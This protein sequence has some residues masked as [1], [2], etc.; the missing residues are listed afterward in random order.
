MPELEQLRVELRRAVGVDRRRAAGQ[1]HA[2]RP[3]P[4]DLLGADVVRQQLRE[5][6]ALAHAPR[7]QLRVLPA[8]VEHHDLSVAAD[9][10]RR[11]VERDST[12][13]DG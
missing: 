1:D 7:D 3:A 4:R 12:V 6:A 13:C 8:V 11:V 9:S 10:R 5:H 2:L